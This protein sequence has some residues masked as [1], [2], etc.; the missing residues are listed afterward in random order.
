MKLLHSGKVRDVYADGDDLVL[1]ASDRISIYD[2][3]LPT[4]IPDKGAVLTQL[5][6]WWFDRLADLV[7]NHVISGDGRPA[8]VRRA[9]ACAAGGSRCCRSSASPA[10]TSPGP[11]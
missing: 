7:P 11:A 2:V 1:V 8:G 9:G 10:A 3:V 4:P 5:S 6:L